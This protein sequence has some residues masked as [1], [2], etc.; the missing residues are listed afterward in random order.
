M[1]SNFDSSLHPLAG[2]GQ[3]GA[4]LRSHP[5]SQTSL[6]AVETWPED[7]KTA[8]QTLLGAI[9]QPPTVAGGSGTDSL[10]N[11][12]LS[13]FNTL[14]VK[15]TRA[16]RSLTDIADIQTVATRTLGQ[17]LGANRVVYAEVVA[18]GQEVLI[19]CSY[20]LGVAPMRGQHRLEDYRR[21]LRQDHPAGQTQV[22]ND[23]PHGTRYTDREQGRYRDTSIAARVDVPLV[24]NSQFVALLSVHQST[25][26]QWTET[27]VRMIEATAEQTWAAVERA[28]AEAA[29]RESE[30][31]NR[32]ILDSSQDCIKVLTLDGYISYINDG[33]LRLLEVE[34]STAVVNTCWTDAWEGDYHREAEAAI[35]AAKAGR[36]GQFGGYLAT[37]KGTP[38]WWHSIITPVRNN[39]G[40]I[41]QLVAISR[42]V[43]EQ[44]YA[45]LAREQL[46]I[47][48]QVAR[49]QAE[50]ANRIKDEFLAVL[51]HELRSPLNPILGWAN[52]LQTR[53]FDAATQQQ[54]LAAIERNAKI[55]MQLIDDLL[56]IGRI[57]RGKLILS[58]ATVD[59][60]TVIRAAM[61][62]IKTA[63]E[64]KA[65]TVNFNV[66]DSCQVR[67]DAGRL[68]Q[69]VWNLLSN[70]VKFTPNGGR[71]D[72]RLA[73]VG[74]HS[75]IT[76]TDTGK[77]IDPAFI[78]YLFQSFRQEDFSTTRQYGGLGLGL[79][80][81][82]YLLDAHGGTITAI[83]P[84][85][86]QGSTFTIQLPLQTKGASASQAASLLKERDLTGLTV[87]I[88]DDSQDTLEL[89]TMLLSA[90]GAAVRTASS[91]A[92]VLA[93]LS[94]FD[95]DVLVCD[96]SMPSM[97]GYELIK[98]IRSLPSSARGKHIPA[99]AL[100]AF[101]R[102]AD[103]QKALESGFQEHIT[104]PV[105]PDT[106]AQAIAGLASAS[107]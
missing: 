42:D 41:T 25:P 95:P 49:E 75:E 30:A 63:A 85:E 70:A 43:S 57:L 79:S 3:V 21:N 47:K 58:E 19:R 4:L 36:T 101:A 104:K 98:R 88:A 105:E 71:V 107:L 50:T 73:S 81:A 68:Q 6:G 16:L 92:A 102:D 74:R 18:G 72:I 52:L 84:G 100:T 59:V 90:Y 14:N 93:S 65:I 86:G 103:R 38:K 64:A 33:G 56:D 29:L 2:G 5:W 24:K 35:A 31:L 67:G 69:V 9:D 32:S 87:L 97:D 26:R 23:I 1:Q 55:Q 40:E 27:E 12:S 46:L 22:V 94:T 28:R 106:L 45:E 83:S 10:A 77:G 48:E 78:P 66:M 82:K 62:V 89:L 99:I 15:L 80:I 17:M 61:E 37:H 76:I 8:V 44:K 20:A 60:A 39:L 96:I 53:S 91:G 54:A 51:S 13:Q 34:D 11:V 7:F